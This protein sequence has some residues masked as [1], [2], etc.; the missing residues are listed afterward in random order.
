VAP[1]STPE[2]R[3]A[4]DLEFVELDVPVKKVWSILE[5][6][7][8]LRVGSPTPQSELRRSTRM[9]R[10]PER[11]SSSLHYLLLTDSGEPECYEEVLQVEAKDK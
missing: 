3:N 9:T 7:E 2:Q 10:A 4:A 5:E 6:N 11:Y 8:K 1:R